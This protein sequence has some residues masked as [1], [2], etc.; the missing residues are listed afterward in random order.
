MTPSFDE[1]LVLVSDICECTRSLIEDDI[2]LVLCE[3][4]DKHCRQIG[5]NCYGGVSVNCTFVCVCVVCS[6]Q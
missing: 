6:Y 4:Q 1:Q 3:N 2:N 5:L